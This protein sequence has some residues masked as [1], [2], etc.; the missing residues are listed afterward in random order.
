MSLAVGIDWRGDELRVVVGQ[1][2]ATS[3][4]VLAAGRWPLPPGA[5]GL[6]SVAGTV[7]DW[8]KA[9]K[10]HGAPAVLSVARDRLIFKELKL[11]NIPAEE[12][13]AIVQFQVTKELTVPLDDVVIDYIPAATPGPAG[14]L[15]VAA[16][17]L[18]KDDLAR[19]TTFAQ[20][21]GVKLQAIVPHGLG[22]HAHW[23]GHPQHAAFADVVGIVSPDEFIV[24]N[25][26]ELVYNRP[27]DRGEDWADDV[28][29]GLAAYDNQA[30]HAPVTAV[31]FLGAAATIPQELA[32]R[33]R[34]PQFSFDPMAVLKSD[35][36]LEDA[37]A[38]APAAGLVQARGLFKPLPV[39]FQ[40]VKQV[41]VKPPRTRLYALVGGAVAAG[42]VALVGLWYAWS[43]WE[44]NQQ[45]ADLQAEIDATKKLIDAY[46]ETDKQLA[47][48]ETWASSD[49]VVLDEL[50][51]LIA[52]FPPIS[53]VR[54]TK[55]EWMPIPVTPT[56]NRPTPAAAS[57]PG[58][59]PATP[60]PSSA[61]KPVAQAMLEV[62]ADEPAKFE[63]LYLALSAQSHW[64]VTKELDRNPN[65]VR[66]FIKIIPLAPKEYG[67]MLSEL[68]HVTQ[69]GDGRRDDAR[70]RPT[71]RPFRGTR[72]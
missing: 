17:V 52:R 6:A 69:P 59:T 3:T 28:R 47:A 25:G 39:N 29:R 20:A 70:P 24:V 22:L 43:H 63:Q 1:A 5:D 54:V 61:A 41:V 65:I 45:L 67:G 51:E 60:P 13:P 31:F 23:L 36:P 44:L 38:Y 12:L 27:L 19:A 33:I 42:L 11:P 46:G 62:T 21:I 68:T 55:A 15:R 9:A 64:K 40:S 30:G 35:V 7:R 56:I 18:R 37:E 4:H 53:G 26:R 50:Y 10:A 48:V 58:T 16:F 2:H 14:D 66:I 32:R 71:T 34:V 57:K 49:V 8:L 72:P